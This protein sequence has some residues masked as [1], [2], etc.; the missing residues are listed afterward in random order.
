MDSFH[1]LLTSL[2]EPN[3]L[4]SPILAAVLKRDR[5]RPGLCWD[6]WIKFHGPLVLRSNASTAAKKFC[7]HQ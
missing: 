5:K 2:R 6:F 3:V 1:C 7:H 4:V